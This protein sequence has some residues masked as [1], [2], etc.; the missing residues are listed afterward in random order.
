MDTTT[1]ALHTRFQIGAVDP[2]IFGGFLEHMGRAVYEGVYDPNCAHA[3]E[4]GL[5]VD[6]MDALRRLQMTAMRYP[7]GNFASGYHWLDGVGPREQRPTLR[8]LAWQSLIYSSVPKRFGS[9]LCHASSR[10]VGRC[11]RG[12]TP[13]SQ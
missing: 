5:R 7:G 11:S 6:V 13:S 4:D 2:R 12:P 9:R 10:R 1:I 3:D 8:E